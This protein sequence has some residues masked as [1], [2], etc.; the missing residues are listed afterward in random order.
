MKKF[1]TAL[2]VGLML[3]CSS[4]YAAEEISLEINGEAVETEVPPQ[5]IDG[6]TMVPVR[7]IFELVGAEVSWDG[8]TKTVT[9]TKDGTTVIM[10]RSTRYPRA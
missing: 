9:G 8:D 7:A 10:I 2:C 5:I 1:L 6:R 3:L 4:V